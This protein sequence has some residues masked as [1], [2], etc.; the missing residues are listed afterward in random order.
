MPF[1]SNN[2]SNNKDDSGAAAASSSHANLCRCASHAGSWYSDNKKK[3]TNRLDNW[4]CEVINDDNNTNDPVN[5]ASQQGKVKAII[6]PH[7]GYT[8]SGPTAAYS[9]QYLLDSI[10]HSKE[11]IKRI[12]VLGPSHHEYLPNCAVTA[13][14]TLETP[15]GDLIVD[16]ETCDALL[17]S[18]QFTIM[19]KDVDETEHSIEMH[20]PFIARVLQSAKRFTKDQDPIKIVPILVGSL[21]EHGR[22]ESQESYGQLLSPYLEDSSSLF[23]ISSDFCHWG[24]RFR[25]Q[26]ADKRFL[27]DQDAEIWQC[28]E[29][30]DKTGMD[31][32]ASKDFSAF[33][34]YLKDFKNT[35]CG[36]HPILVLLHMIY[37]SENHSDE[38]HSNK[39]KITF[40]KYAQ[41]SKCK[42]SRDSSVSYASAV[43]YTTTK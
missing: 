37:Y 20:L 35:I 9:Y 33:Q 32:I 13:C 36:R 21:R 28:I 43:V 17:D 10:K 31:I 41:S 3:L 14:S 27:K 16:E 4:L 24:S 30:L 12:F 19:V 26:W 22:S 39:Y 18:D 40:T 8:Y 34:E 15:L 6:A 42:T 11:K 29:Y 5:T 25:F 1:W 2:N 23:V 38:P 7:A